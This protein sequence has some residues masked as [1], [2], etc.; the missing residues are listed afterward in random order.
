MNKTAAV[1]KTAKDKLAEQAQTIES[2][3][4]KVA[5]FERKETA[6]DI[7]EM[8]IAAGVTD[9]SDLLNEVNALVQSDRDLDSIKVAMQEAGPQFASD[10]TLVEVEE[11]SEGE[12]KEARST[13]PSSVKQAQEELDAT[14]EAL[15]VSAQ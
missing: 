14:L 5:A 8:K 7:V 6:E 11:T 2:L 9:P 13:T 3:T 12:A 4:E 1:L 10:H 15:G